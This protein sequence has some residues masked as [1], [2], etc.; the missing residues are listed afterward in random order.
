MPL[1][2]PVGLC[3]CPPTCRAGCHCECI[4]IGER[5]KR[6][7]RVSQGL[8]VLRHVE[9]ERPCA[10]PDGARCRECGTNASIGPGL[11]FAATAARFIAANGPRTGLSHAAAQARR[12]CAVIT[13]GLTPSRAELNSPN[14]DAMATAS[15]CECA[16]SLSRRC[17]TWLRTV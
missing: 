6:L 16:P 7:Q 11:K 15:S 10:R 8:D 4:Q 3:Q 14:R 12:W 1:D 2:G 5:V 9:H 13:G 17:C